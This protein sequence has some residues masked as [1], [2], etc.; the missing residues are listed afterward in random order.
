M[1]RGEGGEV[2]RGG[3]RRKRKRGR[4]KRKVGKIVKKEEEKKGDKEAGEGP[5]VAHRW[6]LFP[7][8]LSSHPTFRRRFRP[9]PHHVLGR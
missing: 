2:E 9:P 1:G 5:F 4:G 3:G 7:Q 8:G 6:Q